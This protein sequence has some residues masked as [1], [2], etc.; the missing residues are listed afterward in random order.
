MKLSNDTL[1]SLEPSL[2]QIFQKSRDY[3]F[4]SEMWE[5]WRDASGKNFGKMYNDYILLSNEATK[6]YG[7]KDYGEYSRLSFETNDLPEEFD[8][9]YSKFEKLYRLLHAYIRNK[10]TETIYKDKLNSK[11]G[12][13]PAHVMGE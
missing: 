2:S 11:L 13:L 3:E 9:I 4:L 1:I 12:I 10:L 8:K 6:I 7:F 5:A